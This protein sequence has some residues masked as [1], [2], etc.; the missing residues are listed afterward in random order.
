MWE[1]ALDM[2]VAVCIATLIYFTLELLEAVR[3]TALWGAEAPH[4]TSTACKTELKGRSIDPL[5]E[6]CGNRSP[7]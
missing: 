4:S 6:F 5:D 1:R 3:A 7:K 2:I